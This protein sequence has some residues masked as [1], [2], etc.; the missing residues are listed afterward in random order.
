MLKPVYDVESLIKAIPLGG[1]TMKSIR[2]VWDRIEVSRVGFG[3]W[4]LGGYGWG[5]VSEE[6]MVYAVHRAID[7]GVNFFDTA[8][9]YGLGHSE[10]LLG[11][12][13]GAKRKDVIIA[14]K[15]GLTWQKGEVFRRFTDSSPANIIR[16]VDMSLKRLR[17]DYIN[18]YQIHWPDP[19]TPIEDTLE[20]LEKLK[21]AG[22]ILHIGCCNFGIDQLTK[23]L[24]Y[25]QV[26]TMQLCYNLIDRQADKEIMPFGID[27]NI[28]VLAY[29]SLAYG[30]LSGKYDINS[31]FG[32]DDHRSQKA[33]FAKPS[34]ARNLVI[35]DKL[36]LVAKHLGK[37][38]S[39]IALRWVLE[40]PAVWIALVGV[41]NINQIEENAEASNFTLSKEDIEFL[42]EETTS[43]RMRA[44]S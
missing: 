33:Y 19:D 18:L 38:P 13:L 36:K 11:S 37:T 1:E 15:F 10:E 24:E 21:R 12:T 26:E 41:K 25:G 5:K 27:K 34:L 30:L 4:P 22:K 28:G 43:L 16:E 29:G 35:V 23:L 44:L 42:S 20:T 8:P 17:T 14:T 39:Q 32:T 40:N 3:C 7:L 9:L 6:D 2:L 31:S